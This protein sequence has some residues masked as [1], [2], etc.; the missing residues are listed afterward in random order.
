MFKIIKP[1]DSD[2]Q[3]ATKPPATLTG[4]KIMNFINF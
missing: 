1:V 3:I 2:K 4:E